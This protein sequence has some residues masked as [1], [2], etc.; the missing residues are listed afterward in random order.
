MKVN[1]SSE[2]GYAGLATFCKTE[3]AMEP[4][5]LEGADV[6][7][8][9]APFDEGVT[10]RPGTRF[11]PRAIRM[12]DNTPLAPPR[13]PS[14][15]LG[16]DPFEHLRVVDYGDAECVPAN[17]AASHQKVRDRLAEIFAVGAIPIVL[18]GDHSVAYPNLISVAAHLGA[19]NFAVIQ[20][21]SHADTGELWGVKLSHGTPMRLAVEEGAL[22]GDQFM[23]YGLRGYWPHPHE[24]DWMREAG[25]WW[26][27]MDDV[28]ERGFKPSI[29]DLLDEAEAKAVPIHLTLDI[30][31]LDPAYAPATGTPEPGGLSARELLYAVRR[32]CSRLSIASMDLV[33]VSPPYD[34]SDITALVAHRCIIEALSGIALRRVGAEPRPERPLAR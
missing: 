31:V 22:R 29:E 16:I 23:Q 32:I 3:F 14:I 2:P 4:S 12:V 6:V 25:M 30:D 17:L 21:D 27:T 24:W 18:G 8:L 20:F 9:G 19:E 15:P 34:S 26:L 33:E 1:R 7:I 13:R 28:L 11:G 5:E 10:N